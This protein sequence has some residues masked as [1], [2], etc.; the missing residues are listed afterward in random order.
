MISTKPKTADRVFLP[1]SHEFLAQTRRFPPLPIHEFYV[2]FS[3]SITFFIDSMNNMN[4][5]MPI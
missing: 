4:V 5:Y 1:Q 2:F 3:I